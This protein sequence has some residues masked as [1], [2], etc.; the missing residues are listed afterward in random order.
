MVALYIYKKMGSINFGFHVGSNKQQRMLI[1]EE[2]D[3]GCKTNYDIR[4]AGKLFRESCNVEKD[5]KS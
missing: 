1:E 3:V 2:G 4:K 5:A